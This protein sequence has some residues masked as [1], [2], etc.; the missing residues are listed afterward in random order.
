VYWIFSDVERLV[1]VPLSIDHG[2]YVEVV[3]VR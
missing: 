1:Q 2:H 3:F